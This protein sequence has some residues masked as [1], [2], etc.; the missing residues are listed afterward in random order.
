MRSLLEDVRNGS[1]ANR[2]IDENRRGRPEFAKF[3]QRDTEHPIEKVGRELR[4]KM[5]FV[6]PRECTPGQGGA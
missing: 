3:R 1:F 2:W 6:D 4:R 5:P